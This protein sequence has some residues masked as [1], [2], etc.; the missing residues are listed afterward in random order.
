MSLDYNQNAIHS[1][2][3]DRITFEM[4]RIA[5]FFLPIELIVTQAA[6]GL[7]ADYIGYL[8]LIIHPFT[9]LLVCL[10]LVPG[11]LR[12]LFRMP[13][14]SAVPALMLGV[15]VSAVLLDADR[16]MALRF[17]YFGGLSILVG[18]VIS[19]HPQAGTLLK[20]FLYGSIFWMLVVLCAYAWHLHSFEMPD[21]VTFSNH[22]LTLRNPGPEAAN[23][24]LFFLLI[25]NVN[26]VANYAVLITIV[27]YYL[28]EIK[29][30]SNIT[31][32]ITCILSAIVSFICFSRGAFVAGSLLAIGIIVVTIYDYVRFR[33]YSQT[34]ILYVAM[35]IAPVLASI[36]TQEFRNYWLDTTTIERRI[37]LASEV[38]EAGQV[39][40]EET[41]EP[42][43]PP[44]RETPA[45][46]A[47][48]AQPHIAGSDGNLPPSSSGIE[49]KEEALQEGPS[50]IFGYGIGKYGELHFNNPLAGTHNFFVDIWTSGGILSFISIVI[51]I[52]IS[53]LI[54]VYRLLSKCDIYSITG[55]AGLCT[56]SVL[57]FRE[58]D[59]AY[60]LATSMGGIFL[61]IF[62]GLSIMPHEE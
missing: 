41:G 10:I 42:A 44:E 35:L 56:I 47:A 28:K 60:L 43:P 23:N 49:D 19:S 52:F 30:I 53:I 55:V 51:L 15:L 14:L 34:S 29:F 8:Y 50:F 3:W 61:G 40:A 33:R 17:V 24:M 39:Y 27:A 45:Q 18:V 31:F 38:G 62:V 58:Y 5:L 13:L 57:A 26:K 22:V 4:A 16:E 11:T 6:H 21:W 46:P 32:T 54:G 20:T 9:A 12:H 7:F 2:S 37:L 1:A 59:V 25:G 36:A 48:P